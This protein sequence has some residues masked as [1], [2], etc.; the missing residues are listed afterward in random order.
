M[1]KNKQVIAFLENL[2]NDLLH[3]RIIIPLEG[4]NHLLTCW[5]TL[6]C[7]AKRCPVY[8]KEK[9]RCW[10]IIGTFCKKRK[11]YPTFKTKCSSCLDCEVYRGVF[12]NKRF[13][14]FELMNNIVSLVVGYDTSLLSKNRLI[15][16]EIDS[17]ADKFALTDK[18]TSILLYILAGFR[19]IDIQTELC[20]SKNTIKTHIRHLFS[21]IGAVSVDNLRE[22]LSKTIR[23][24]K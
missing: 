11:P 17:M 15:L 8:G 18:E 21:K 13:R 3:H 1:H 23:N 22:I 6:N 16:A 14:A 9:K 24:R 7:K 20:I 2:Q 19:R 5:K 12:Q 4:D 10:Q